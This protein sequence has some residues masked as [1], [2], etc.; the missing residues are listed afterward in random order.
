V[1]LAANLSFLF[2]ESADFLGRF[3]SAAHAGFDAVEFMFPGDG[4]YIHTSDDVAKELEE[5][6]LKQA[7][8]SCSV[9]SLRMQG[10]LNDKVGG[11]VHRSS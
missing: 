1:R 9:H 8:W 3:R 2:K 7:S 10:M 5:H 6:S 4:G 11:R